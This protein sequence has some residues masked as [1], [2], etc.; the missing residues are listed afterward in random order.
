MIKKEFIRFEIINKECMLAAQKINHILG[1]ITSS[2][3]EQVKGGDSAPLVCSV[4]S[5]PEYPGLGFSAQE[6][7]RPVRAGPKEGH[8]GHERAGAPLL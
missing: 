3:G 4:K 8:K 2:V 6:R 7:H 5:P 1:C